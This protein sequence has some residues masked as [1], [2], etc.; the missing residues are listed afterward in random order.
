[1]NTN[2]AFPAFARIIT[3]ATARQ[4]DIL[5]I[6]WA[7]GSMPEITVAGRSD[8]ETLGRLIN[9]DEGC[10]HVMDA[11]HRHPIEVWSRNLRGYVLV[12]NS[13]EV[14]D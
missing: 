1:M 5:S 3:A 6:H 4:L 13:A 10:E 11:D 8:A 2:L 12:I 9:G 14:E 7:Y